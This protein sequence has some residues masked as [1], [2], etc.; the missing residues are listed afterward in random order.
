MS[1]NL[2]SPVKTISGLDPLSLPVNH[3]RKW[4][5][6]LCD[7]EKQELEQH[8]LILASLCSKSPE[9]LTPPTT[10]HY[11]PPS[12]EDYDDMR[13][14]GTANHPKSDPKKRIRT[15][16]E[17]LRVLEKTYERETNPSQSLREEIA[18]KL[19]MTPRRVQ[20]WFQNKRAKERRI[21]KSMISESPSISGSQNR[22]DFPGSERQL[23]GP[24]IE[25]VPKIHTPTNSP[26]GSPAR[27]NNSPS[28]SSSSPPPHVQSLPLESMNTYL[29]PPPQVQSF[30]VPEGIGRRRDSTGRLLLPF[31]GDGSRNPFPGPG[32]VPKEVREGDW[33]LPPLREIYNGI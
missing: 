30:S 16:P 13:V 21:T 19:G 15:T 32:N 27:Q 9:A 14:S 4:D 1:T 6:I 12:S 8:A 5:D 24:I 20:V 11:S 33:K 29:P 25:S 2:L 17:Q 28:E 22:T 10:L 26:K 7:N 23:N 3:K 31:P 18:R